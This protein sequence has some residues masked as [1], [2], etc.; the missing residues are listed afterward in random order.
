MLPALI[1]GPVNGIPCLNV[2]SVAGAACHGHFFLIF[3]GW[4]GQSRGVQPELGAGSCL[5]LCYCRCP[6]SEA[7]HIQPRL[8]AWEDPF[9]EAFASLFLISATLHG[10][11]KGEVS[12]SY[13]R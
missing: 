11:G 13:P 12:S 1:S 2:G 10:A 9:R 5:G 3:M 7:I 6:S 4:S 8:E